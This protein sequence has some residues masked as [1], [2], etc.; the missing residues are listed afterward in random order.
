MTDR[1]IGSGTGKCVGID[2]ATWFSTDPAAVAWCQRMC[3]DCS[4]RVGCLTEAWLRDEQWGV[5]GGVQFSPRVTSCWV[6]WNQ[7]RWL[8]RGVDVF[9]VRTYRGDYA[10]LEEAQ[11]RAAAVLEGSGQR[12]AVGEELRASADT[13]FSLRIEKPRPRSAS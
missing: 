11:Q 8:V 4:L 2:T 1:V 5:W 7:G 9:G 3:G 6:E 13:R 12:W 10:T